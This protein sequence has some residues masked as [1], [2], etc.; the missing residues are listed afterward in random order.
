MI[1]C[2]CPIILIGCLHGDRN[3]ILL[4]RVGVYPVGRI[5]KLRLRF[6]DNNTAAVLEIIYFITN[7]EICRMQK[8]NILPFFFFWYTDF[9]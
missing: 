2:K 8:I 3:S 6:M 4:L 5:H 1:I 7:V 9:S